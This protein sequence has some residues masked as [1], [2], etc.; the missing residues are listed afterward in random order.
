[1]PGLSGFTRGGRILHRSTTVMNL[2]AILLVMTWPARA[3][4][5]PA[6]RIQEYL[7]LGQATLRNP[8]SQQELREAVL[9][10]DGVAAITALFERSIAE[11]LT[12]EGRM[13]TPELGG[14]ATLSE[15]QLRF[16]DY[17]DPTHAVIRNLVRLKE[18]PR[19]SLDFLSQSAE[20]L[21]I[22]KTTGGLHAL[23]YQMAERT[24]EEVTEPQRKL[25]DQVVLS[26][27]SIHFKTWE[28]VPEIQREMIQKNDWR[29]RYLGFWHI[30]PPRA[31][32]RELTAGIEPS[33]ADLTNALE[34]GQF[35]TIVFQPE[36]FDFYD[37]S[38]VAA[39]GKVDLS[40]ARTIP[41]RSPQW[42][43]VFQALL[44][45]AK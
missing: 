17:P 9:S 15:G 27:V 8:I 40:Q 23:L 36:G 30:H 2:A 35:V 20:G 26:A 32:D 31:L 4:G 24:M 18:N 37:L 43:P 19:A 3:Q 11:S 41:Y 13:V 21:K 38:P 7:R 14:E 5:T 1:P 28:A 45:R 44:S 29:G 25:L 42:K 39:S 6:D 16:I 22:L 10:P 34:R 12:L 33:L